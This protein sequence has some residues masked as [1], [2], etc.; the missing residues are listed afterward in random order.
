VEQASVGVTGPPARLKQ[1]FRQSQIL[2]TSRHSPLPISGGLCHVPNVYGDE[3]IRNI[4]RT[5]EVLERWGSQPVHLPLISPYTG[6][7]FPAANAYSLIEAICV[8]ALTKPLYFDKLAESAVLQMSNSQREIPLSSCLILHY[9]TSLISETIISDVTNKLSPTAV[10]RQDLLDWV[11]QETYIPNQ[12]NANPSLPQNSKLA[13]VGMACRMPGG[14]D[15]VEKFWEL[16][17]DGEDTHTTVP[18]DRFDVETHFDPNDE[19]ENTIGT[20]FGNFI[21]NPGLFDAGFFNMSPREVR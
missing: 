2:S 15:N 21:S 6:T 8:E 12:L 7:P 5:A 14:A 20:R 4:L 16:L 17:V 18:P 9:R 19:I 10:Q 1:L 3:D 13:V 11:I